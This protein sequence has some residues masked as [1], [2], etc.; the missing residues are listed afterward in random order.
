MMLV[1]SGLRIFNYRK[2]TLGSDR[3][4]PLFIA[5]THLW[6]ESFKVWAMPGRLPRVQALMDQHLLGAQGLM[7][8]K[9]QT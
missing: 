6:N 8:H 4:T 2:K 9:L 5:P 1:A 7:D 3:R